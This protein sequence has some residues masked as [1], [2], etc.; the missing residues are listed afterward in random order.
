MPRFDVYLLGY[1]YRNLSVPLQHAKRINA[2][3]GMLHPTV[4]VDDRAVGTWKSR[5]EKN[6]LNVLGEPFDSLMPTMLAGLEAEVM[7][8]AR[9]LEVRAI[10]HFPHPYK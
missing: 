10:L 1:Q 4:L 9:F 8:I 6:H 5:R 7:H 2:G 3:G